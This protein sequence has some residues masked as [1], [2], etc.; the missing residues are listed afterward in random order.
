MSGRWLCQHSGVGESRD[1]DDFLGW[2][3]DLGFWDAPAE[4][5]A[6]TWPPRPP[7]LA[8]PTP[9]APGRTST[10]APHKGAT[11]SPGTAV[12]PPIP[13]STLPQ[14]TGRQGQPPSVRV[15]LSAA[16]VIMLFATM[17]NA[18]LMTGDGTGASPLALAVCGAAT[19]VLGTLSWSRGRG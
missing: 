5:S 17:W 6:M 14:S 12:R 7:V 13:S 2:A 10:P 18:L 19:V 1:V 11:A 9:A 3:P 16:F 15:P 8:A 4:P